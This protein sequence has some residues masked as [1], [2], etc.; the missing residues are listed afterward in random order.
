MQT[1]CDD[2]EAVL[3]VEGQHVGKKLKCPNCKSVFVASKYEEEIIEIS[4][5]SIVELSS[6][7][8]SVANPKQEKLSLKASTRSVYADLVNIG[9]V[10]TIVNCVLIFTV[11]FSPFLLFITI[12]F[13]VI[14]GWK[15]MWKYLRSKNTT[16]TITPDRIHMESYAFKFLGCEDYTI[17]GKE[18]K[19]ISV[20]SS[21]YWDLWFFNCG[22]VVIT[23]SGDN[24]DFALTNVHYPG[25]LKNQI[26]RICLGVN[27]DNGPVEKSAVEVCMETLGGDPR[28]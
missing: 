14:L 15:A 24:Q 28:I 23:V 22:R 8:A 4:A 13:V 6:S 19:Q 21:S 17:N 7:P 20:Y 12:M 5:N 2:C 18:I 10:I 11:G 9:V 27:D 26:E 3:S 16:Y 25:N 1:K